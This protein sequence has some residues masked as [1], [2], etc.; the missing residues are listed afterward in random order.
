MDPPASPTPEVPSK[1]TLLGATLAALA[2][3]AVLLVGVVLPAEYGIDPL[4][5]GE[6]LGLV[7]LSGPVGEIPVREDG[8]TA[9]PESYRIDRRSFE[10]TPGAFVEYK[11]RLEAGET[12]VYS[13]TATGP[14]RSEMHSE[15]DGAPDGVAE[16][17]EVQEET[18]SGH[19]SYWAPFP[20]DHG[21]YWLNEG[22]EP[23]TV[24][25]HAAGYFDDSIEYPASGDPILRDVT[26]TPAE[27]YPEEPEP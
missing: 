14:V 10:L 23:V 16:F 27:G 26:A 25:L 7:V 19:G 4:G 17:F 2:L 12:M 1:R 8:L 15:P 13:W 22:S 6:A 3:A 11:L 9:E 18:V 24:T 21:W 20:G 5:V